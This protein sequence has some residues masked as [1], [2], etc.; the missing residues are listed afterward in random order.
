MR[1]TILVLAILLLAAAPA[2]SSE[3]PTY[4]LLVKEGSW[5][6]YE[7]LEAEGA[8]IYGATVE[9]GST[10]EFRL[11]GSDRLPAEGPGGQVIFYAE[12]PRCDVLVDGELVAENASTYLLW[13][14]WPAEEGFWDALGSLGG[15]GLSLEDRGD[16]V[17]VT[18]KSA[19]L[20]LRAEWEVRKAD[21]LAL[22]YGAEKL[23]GG[24]R[25]RM[26]V[27]DTGL[28]VVAPPGEGT[29][30]TSEVPFDVWS[31]AAAALA[32]FIVAGLATLATRE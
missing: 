18:I 11:V 2:S 1:W 9:P 12:W 13:P 26:A 31:C 5:A 19:E 15:E 4:S 27:K 30:A 6:L 32:I 21:G 17:L 3:V 20:G 25:L 28:S 24:M 8:K 7:V 22:S 29:Q 10:V 23:N 14:F 16:E